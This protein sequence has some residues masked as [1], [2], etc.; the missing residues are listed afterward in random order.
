MRNAFIEYE[1]LRQQ[2]DLEAIDRQLERWGW[3]RRPDHLPPAWGWRVRL[4]KALIRLGRWLEGKGE[5]GEVAV[6]QS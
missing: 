5:D 3:F 6:P 4:G 2:R 1:A